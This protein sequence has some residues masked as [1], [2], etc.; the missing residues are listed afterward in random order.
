METKKTLATAAVLMLL[1]ACGGGGGGGSDPTPS[2][3]GNGKITGSVITENFSENSKTIELLSATGVTRVATADAQ[4]NFEFTTEGLEAPLLLRLRLPSGEFMNAVSTSLPTGGGVIN[5][6]A[7]TQ[8]AAATISPEGDP[9]KLW[10]LP[11]PE[12]AM[13]IRGKHDAIV[14]QIGNAV[15][16]VASALKLPSNIDFTHQS[17]GGSNSALGSLLDGLQVNIYRVGSDAVFSLAAARTP[18]LRAIWDTNTQTAIPTIPLSPQLPPIAIA[19]IR[20]SIDAS[21]AATRQGAA[22]FD[23]AKMNQSEVNRILQ[24]MQNMAAN[25]NS[26]ANPMAL[27]KQF[28]LAMGFPNAF[29]DEITLQMGGTNSSQGLELMMSFF[30]PDGQHALQEMSAMQTSLVSID[31]S[32]QIATYKIILGGKTY[33]QNWSL[34]TGSSLTG[35]T[36]QRN[37]ARECLKDRYTGPSGSSTRPSAEQFLESMEIYNA[38]NFEVQYASCVW[39]GGTTGSQNSGCIDRIATGTTIPNESTHL[40]EVRS[41]PLYRERVFVACKSPAKPVFQDNIPLQGATPAFALQ[42]QCID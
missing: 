23:P 16:P 3:P 11:A 34:T 13:L 25:P 42:W 12:R 29:A 26:S 19:P 18:A 32:S 4:G 41:G 24:E 14:T 5:I 28:M 39:Q 8:L 33:Y 21:Y 17:T 35:K 1:T 30:G 38:C 20:A 22:Q 37:Y 31:Q 2:T 6:N 40:R 15:T 27:F 36:T 7:L 10:N 9:A